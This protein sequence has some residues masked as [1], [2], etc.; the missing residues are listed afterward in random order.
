MANDVDDM[1]VGNAPVRKLSKGAVEDLI[2]FRFRR[3]Q[4]EMSR[5]FKQRIAR[6]DVNPGMFSAM[7]L[8]Q[9]NPGL[10]QSELASEIG[11]DRATVVALLDA[12]EKNGWARRTRDSV[13]RRRHSLSITPQGGREVARLEQLAHENEAAIRAALGA[14]SLADLGKL[15]DRIDAALAGEGPLAESSKTPSRRR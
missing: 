15:L 7:A 1:T 4:N 11:M 10:S 13:D 3:I 14:K 2:G 5:R 8:I 12:L 6:V 9:A